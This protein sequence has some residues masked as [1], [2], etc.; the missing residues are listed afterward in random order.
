[1][2]RNGKQR[3]ARPRI[4]L[5][6]S[7]ST[8]EAAFRRLSYEVAFSEYAIALASELNEHGDFIDPSD[9]IVEIG[10]TLNRIARKGAALYA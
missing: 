7:A 1:M 10:L 8:E 3:P 4:E 2:T 5:R 6:Q 9:A